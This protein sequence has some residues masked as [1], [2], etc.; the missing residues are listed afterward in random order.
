MR[1]T[2]RALNMYRAEARR[3]GSYVIARQIVMTHY[4]LTAARF[5]QMMRM[6]GR[7]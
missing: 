5:D 3:T 4:R 7:A 1:L 2:E 6:I